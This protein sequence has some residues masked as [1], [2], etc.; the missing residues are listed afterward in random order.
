LVQAR[1][2]YSGAVETA[3]RPVPEGLIDEALRRLDRGVTEFRRYLASPEGRKVRRRV[4]QAAIIGAPLLFRLKFIRAHPV[5][6]LI[7]LVGG[8]AL[9]VKMAEALRDWE[10][11]EE[12]AEDLGL[13][14]EDDFQ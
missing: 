3:S 2:G 12:L 6:R 14:E 8:A 11:I 7:G 10:P 13:K 1:G 9:V 4:A 5:G